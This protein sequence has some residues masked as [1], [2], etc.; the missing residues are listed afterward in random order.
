[1]PLPNFEQAKKYA[2]RRLE[3]ELSSHLVY[4]GI[5]HTREEVVPAAERLANLEGLRGE[6]L[7]LLVTAAWFHDTGFI[8]QAP[9]HE[10]ISVQ[11]AKEVLPSFG[12]TENQINIISRAILATALPQSPSS[13]LEEILTDADLDTLGCENFMQRNQD[14]RQELS[15]LGTQFTD[16][17]WYWGQLTFLEGHQYF[18][19]S[20][21]ALRD[22]QKIRNIN[23]LR[24]ILERLRQDR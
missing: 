24:K 16:E 17:Q 11:L 7:E 8:K 12:Y 18:T 19:V 14:L 10:S 9:D 21:R 22:T 5:K 13:L 6:A 1:M 15:F 23:E 2:E 20:A 4:H 3:Q